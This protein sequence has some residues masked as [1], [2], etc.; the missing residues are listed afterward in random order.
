MTVTDLSLWQTLRVE[1]PPPIDLEDLLQPFQQFGVNLGL[2]RIQHLLKRLGNPHH[3]V[4]I[5]HVAGTNGKGSVCAYLTAVL[6]AAGYRVGCYTSPHL[7]SWC[8]RITINQAA[9]AP[10]LLRQTLQTVIA[11]IDPQQPTPTQFEVLT[12]AA[13]LYFA[14][15]QVD[16]AVVEVG[17]GGRL[18]ATNVCEGEM[19][20]HRPNPLATVI[21]SISREHWQVLGSTLEAIAA[22]KAGILKADRPAIIGPMLPEAAHVIQERTEGLNC[23]TVWVQPAQQVQRD[24]IERCE[25]YQVLCWEGVTYT[26]GLQGEIQRTNSAIALATLRVLRDQ[27]WSISDEAVQIGMAQA[28]W[29][30]R[31]QWLIWNDRPLLVDGAHNPAAAAALSQYVNSLAGRTE[32]GVTWVMGMLSTKEHDEIFRHLLRAGDRLFT[33]PVP[34]HSTADPQ[35]LAHLARS[36]CPDLHQIEVAQEVQTALHQAQHK[37]PHGIAVLCGSLYLLGHFFM[38]LVHDRTE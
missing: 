18:D 17:L 1:F 4:S 20:G 27:G 25:E 21:T 30:G 26:I 35:A 3:H 28:V 2:S 34:D 22:E 7:V 16:L 38:D 33:V 12:A 9:I 19:L 14:Q 29:P 13:W 31:L 15:A 6:T 8:E 11:A 24:P 36:L 23:P 10:E 32:Q 5:V 37:Y